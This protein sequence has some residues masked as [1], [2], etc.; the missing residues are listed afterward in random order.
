M[1]WGG[2]DNKDVSLNPSDITVYNNLFAKPYAWLSGNYDIKELFEMKNATRILIFNN[3]LWNNA[4][5]GQAGSAIL[6]RSVNQEGGCTWCVVRD[7]TLQ[8]NILVNSPRGLSTTSELAQGGPVTTPTTNIGIYDN[9]LYQI[10][11]FP[12]LIVGDPGGNA[13]HNVNYVN[14]TVWGSGT[15]NAAVYF[16]WDPYPYVPLVNGFNFINNVWSTTLYGITK[17]GGGEG[18]ATMA[19]MT[20]GTVALTN[21]IIAGGSSGNYSNYP[22]NYFGSN[23][24]VVNSACGNFNLSSPGSYGP[25]PVGA[26]HIPSC[27]GSVPAN[28]TCSFQHTGNCNSVPIPNAVTPQI[29]FVQASNSPYQGY[30]ISSCATC[31]SGT[32]DLTIDFAGVLS[33]TATGLSDASHGAT[34]SPTISASNAAGAG[35]GVVSVTFQ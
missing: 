11:N 34:W 27:T 16:S 4:A 29:G 17:D 14:N 25:P 20:T 12:F 1:I 7:A 24:S 6:F 8:Q 21:N 13:S 30:S 10:G 22:G 3:V 5:Q 31:P 35:T 33:L 28:F 9:L 15:M 2:D 18:N 19:A 23:P 32:N 26:Q